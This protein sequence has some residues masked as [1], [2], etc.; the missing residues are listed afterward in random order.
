[1]D[2]SQPVSGQEILLTIAVLNYSG[3]RDVILS[4][5]AVGGESTALLLR[6]YAQ[7]LPFL[8]PSG[9]LARAENVLRRSEISPLGEPT[10]SG[11]DQERETLTGNEPF[12]WSSYLH[13]TPLN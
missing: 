10:L 8:G 7:E 9:A 3:V 1:M 6:E 5:W 11:A 2:T 12:F 4:R 13:T